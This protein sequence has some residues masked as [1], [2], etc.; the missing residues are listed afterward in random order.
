M[1]RKD[2]IIMLRDK[3]V[4]MGHAVGF[5]KLDDMHNKWI[6]EMVRGTEDDTLQAHRGS[7][8]TTCVDSIY[9]YAHIGD[10]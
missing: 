5:T 6:V 9:I 7:Y 8:K 2:A 10:G 4:I 3:P 1:N